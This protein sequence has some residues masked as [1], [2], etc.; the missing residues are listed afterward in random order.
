MV[1]NSISNCVETYSLHT[2]GSKNNA[3]IEINIGNETI[4]TTSFVINPIEVQIN[5]INFNKHIEKIFQ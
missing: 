4:K 3:N 5:Q 1:I 2:S